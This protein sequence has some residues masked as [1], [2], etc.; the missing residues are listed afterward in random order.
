[1]GST[2]GRT[3]R[4]LTG[5]I[6]GLL[7]AGGLAAVPSSA[8]ATGR[9]GPDAVGLA[10]N[11]TRLMRFDT[12]RP[13][14]I[15]SWSRIS[16][17]QGDSRLV[18]IDYRMQNGRLYGWATPGGIYLLRSGAS[19]TKVCQLSGA[20][21]GTAF[22]VDFNPAANAL[23]VISNT[24]Q[25]LRQPFGTGAAPTGATVADGRGTTWA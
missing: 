7:L 19:A 18:G 15:S 14:R 9:G 6:T 16:G 23:Q 10:G 25:N 8:E 5:I 13:G 17:L 2:Q 11:G 21:S 4:K 12:D 22:G 3:G 1:M 24:G 20:L